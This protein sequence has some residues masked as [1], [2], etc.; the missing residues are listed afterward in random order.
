MKRWPTL[1]FLLLSNP[2]NADS[3]TWSFRS[4]L[5]IDKWNEP[6]LPYVAT[7]PSGKA[8]TPKN[9]RAVILPASAAQLKMEASKSTS[10][11]IVKREV[12]SKLDTPADV[13]KAQALLLPPSNTI[14]TDVF[15]VAT[16]Y[17]D[18]YGLVSILETVAKWHCSADEK[19][20]DKINQ[21]LEILLSTGGRIM[22]TETFLLSNGQPWILSTITYE[23][24]VGR[25]IS[26]VPLRSRLLEINEKLQ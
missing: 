3:E 19:C 20:P 24:Q 1:A 15:H 13:R 25:E 23:I 12:L 8:I 22:K 17:V 6:L 26:V 14:S 16:G 10:K 11:R 2:L 5:V 7:V 4:N 9:I 21:K 18:Q